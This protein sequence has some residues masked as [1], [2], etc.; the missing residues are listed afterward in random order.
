MN[1]MKQWLLLFCSL[2]FIM[3]AMAI[4]LYDPTHP[5]SAALQAEGDSYGITV[6]S[7]LF[8]NKRHIAV[9]N[10]KYVKEGDMIQGLKIIKIHPDSVV[11]QS[12]KKEF[13]VPVHTSVKHKLINKVTPHDQT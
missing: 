3:K 7:I 9:V 11:F 10:G 12:D 13:F 5:T 2:F 8:S 1:E 4:P 6:S